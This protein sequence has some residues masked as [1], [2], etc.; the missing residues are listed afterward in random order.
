MWSVTVKTLLPQATLMN[1]SYICS[2]VPK[3]LKEDFE[4][5]NSDTTE[6]MQALKGKV[7]HSGHEVY[8][9]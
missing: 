1:I 2:N 7:M 4:A 9:K 3:D 8:N 5:E 6:R